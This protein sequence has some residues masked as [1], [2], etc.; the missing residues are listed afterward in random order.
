M[1]K[2]FERFEIDGIQRIGTDPDIYVGDVRFIFREEIDGEIYGHDV[3]IRVRVK[4]SSS[5]S[6]QS[7]EQ[8]IFSEARDLLAQ[9]G[10][11]IAGVT[12]ESLFQM[13]RRK[14]Q[15]AASE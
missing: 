10:Q 7:L 15:E 1:A 11:H 13:V 12:S 8:K 3:D 14:E 9:T 2:T 4:Q 6:V 5:D